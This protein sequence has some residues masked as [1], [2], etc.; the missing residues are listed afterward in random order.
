MSTNCRYEFQLKHFG[1]KDCKPRRFQTLQWSRSKFLFVIYRLFTFTFQLGWMIAG[2]I[3]R[4]DSYFFKLSNWCMFY[5]TIYYGFACISAI[6]GLFV[7]NEKNEKK[8][9]S[10][11]CGY[12]NNALTQ[13]T[14]EIKKRKLSI[15][16]SIDVEATQ[17][18]ESDNDD[19]RWFHKI[20]W[21]FHTIAFDT[22]V[23]VTAVYW[24]AVFPTE[25]KEDQDIHG[26][27][28]H[29]MNIG[30]LF[31]DMLFVNTP[32][33]FLHTIYM[34]LACVCYSVFL[35]IIHFVGLESSVYGFT[36]FD[37]NPGLAAGVLALVTFVGSWIFHSLWFGI[38]HFR[39]FL[40]R[41]CH[42]E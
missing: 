42:V 33:R 15:S 31:I 18:I 11:T 7:N 40:S 21:I 25:A 34:I 6:H 14:E 5:S 24:I 16:E 8:K 13:S 12:Y 41:S 3:G 2:C 17:N 35:V 39:W 27:A 32:V 10:A 23:L 28:K 26:Y 4:S 22:V 1:F 37:E 9:S 36:N 29:A 20:T 30:L 19:L 38:Y